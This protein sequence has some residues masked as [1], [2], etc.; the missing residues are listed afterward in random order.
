MPAGEN[1]YAEAAQGP[2]ED[3]Y[4]LDL[5]GAYVGE[6]NYGDALPLYEDIGRKD[7]HI[8]V[9]GTDLADHQAP[10]GFLLFGANGYPVGYVT[11]DG[12]GR[13]IE[14]QEDGRTPVAVPPE[15]EK[16]LMRLTGRQKMQGDDPAHAQHVHHPAGEHP[17]PAG[18]HPYARQSGQPRVVL[19]PYAMGV[20]GVNQ[21]EDRRAMYEAFTGLARAGS[22]A[23]AEWLR[24]EGQR[25]TERRAVVEIAEPRGRHSSE[26][27]QGGRQ[28][29]RHSQTVYGE[30]A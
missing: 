18:E 22:L 12:R 10:E 21:A 5:P 2:A 9:R 14:Y 25:T 17:E 27:R 29:R 13:E 1:P 28:S 4:F 7:P 20:I 30:V 15:V 16:R 26:A 6:T 19:T 3:P 11:S 24:S 23:A 8:I